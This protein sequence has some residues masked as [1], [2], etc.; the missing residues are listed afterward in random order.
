MEIKDLAWVGIP[1]GL[2]LLFKEIKPTPAVLAGKY[3]KVKCVDTFKARCAVKNVGT[4]KAVV[5]IYAYAFKVPEVYPGISIYA[6][7]NVEI[8]PGMEY[9]TDWKEAHVETALPDGDYDCL[10]V[11]YDSATQK[12]L[13]RAWYKDFTGQY[14]WT[15]TSPVAKVSISW[16]E[17]G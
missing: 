10:I 1:L 3:T 4:A 2:A 12:E 17:I 9:I 7:K 5:D 15:V 8:P 14:A 16:V 11:V 6:W 13:A